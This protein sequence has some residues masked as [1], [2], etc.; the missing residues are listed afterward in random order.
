MVESGTEYAVYLDSHVEIKTILQQCFSK[1]VIG[2]SLYLTS[3]V[4]FDFVP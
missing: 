4:F 1:D 2:F 3:V